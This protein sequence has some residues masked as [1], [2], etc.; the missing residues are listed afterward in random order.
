M[1]PV[2]HFDRWKLWRYITSEDTL[3]TTVK[4]SDLAAPR[5][6]RSKVI[7]VS[8]DEQIMI[9]AFGTDANNET[10]TLSIFGWGENGPG[11]KL[12]QLSCILGASNFTERFLEDAGDVPNTLPFF[13]VDTYTEVNDNVGGAIGG[14]STG[15][16]TAHYLFNPL[17]YRYLEAF[18]TDCDG[19]TGVEAAKVGVIWKPV[20]ILRAH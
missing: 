18:L 14:P 9:R 16:V 7:C 10:F 12:L 11:E 20:S 1:I 3:R 8:G 6:E 15:I 2:N 4:P 5:G 17:G 19:V 13:E